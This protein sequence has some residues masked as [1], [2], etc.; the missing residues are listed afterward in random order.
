MEK[1][2]TTKR[3][4]GKLTIHPTQLYFTL[5]FINIYRTKFVLRTTQPVR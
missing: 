4:I 2:I 5:S 3:A 1:H